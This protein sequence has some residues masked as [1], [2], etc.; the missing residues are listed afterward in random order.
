M[1]ELKAKGIT[2]P[3]VIKAGDAPPL[4]LGPSPVGP[5]PTALTLDMSANP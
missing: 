2:E 1:N 3:I 5:P 4:D